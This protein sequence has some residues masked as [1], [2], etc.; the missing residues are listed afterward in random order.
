MKRI[1][2]AIDFSDVT[3]TIVATAIELA[4]ALGGNVILFHVA[5]SVDPW[6]VTAFDM[7]T[8]AVQSD[9][10]YAEAEAM[11]REV[12][13]TRVRE[14]VKAKGLDATI[15]VARGDTPQALCEE[16]EAL[17]PDMIVIGSHR[18]G[19]FHD[20]LLGGVCTRVVRKAT[21]PV[22]VVH[23]GDPLPRVETE[24]VSYGGQASVGK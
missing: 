1:V 21:C 3:D 22:L 10:G 18:H 6:G 2:A 16:L 15:H 19:V 5:P 20:M 23:T 17:K 9:T 24:R 7:Y 8:V 13:L 4:T 14:A 11:R 12:S